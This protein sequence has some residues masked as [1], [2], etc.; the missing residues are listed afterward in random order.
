MASALD[1]IRVLDLTRL[2]PGPFCTMLLADFGAEVIKIEDPQMGDY[3]RWS[4]PLTGDFGAAFSMLN[5]NKK[6]MRLDLRSEAGREIFLALAEGADVVV[7][8]FRPGVVE[9]L[10]I[11]A[12]SVRERN[13][14]I[15]YCSITGYGRT[16]PYRTRAGHDLNY[17][18]R[19]G[20]LGSGE[21]AIHPPPLQVADFAGGGLQAA[22]AILVALFH[23]ERSGQG[24]SI[25]VSMRE[26]VLALLGVHAAETLAGGGDPA[27]ARRL[28]GGAAPCY[29]VYRTA[30][31][32]YMALGALEPKFWAEFCRAIDREDLI[33]AQFPEGD[34]RKRLEEELARI[35]AGKTL[36]QW[37]ECFKGRDVCCEP[38]LTLSEA[39]D[40]PDFT[41]RKSLLDPPSS[42]APSQLRAT[43][44]FSETPAT[45]RAPAPLAG[46]H[47]REIL[48]SIGLSDEEIE[49]LEKR[50]IV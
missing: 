46:E 26:G 18:A 16:G 34:A 8:G 47:T 12:A 32:R 23:R 3:L 33:E 41:D 14:R 30:D 17:V 2:Y 50:G 44:L 13:A 4:P 24:Q 29:N 25:D 28:L 39:I 45:Y 11:D 42:D 48:L 37:V 36:A 49:S 15:V 5:R 27:P 35:F 43:P 21:E 40:D 9:R 1:G 22:F 10:G 19:A 6:G 31:G 7:E 38:V 20:L